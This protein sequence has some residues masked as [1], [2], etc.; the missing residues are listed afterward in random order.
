[1][2]ANSAWPTSTH[3]SRS[4]AHYTLVSIAFFGK[5]PWGMYKSTTERVFTHLNHTNDITGLNFFL[6]LNANLETILLEISTDNCN[7]DDW[8]SMPT[9][10][11]VAANLDN[12][13][14]ARL[15]L[16]HGANVVQSNELDCATYSAIHAALGTDGA[17]VPGLP[18]WP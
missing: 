4:T 7:D 14:M 12:V 8:G 10:L 1:M 9:A 17:A 15:L 5:K 11:K 3:F 2:T 16:E 18:R 6:E 13:P